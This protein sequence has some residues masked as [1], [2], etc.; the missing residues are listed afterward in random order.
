MISIYSV[1]NLLLMR[2]FN[3]LVCWALASSA[4]GT[5]MSAE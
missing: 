1:H 4:D 5:K 3:D 2:F